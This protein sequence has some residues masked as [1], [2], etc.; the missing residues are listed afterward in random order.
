MDLWD[1]Y[2]LSTRVTRYEHLKEGSRKKKLPYRTYFQKYQEPDL[3]L[4]VGVSEVIGH[5]PFACNALIKPPEK[6]ANQQNNDNSTAK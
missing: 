2:E 4:K 6:G 3:G 5:T 1:L